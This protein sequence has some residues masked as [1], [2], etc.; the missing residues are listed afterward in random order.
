MV[1]SPASWLK[2][3]PIPTPAAP[4]PWVGR[5]APRVPLVSTHQKVG[6]DHLCVFHQSGLSIHQPSLSVLVLSV[7]SA[8]Q[9]WLALDLGGPECSPLRW[10]LLGEGSTPSST[11]PRGELAS[12]EQS[13]R[14]LVSV[15]G[16]GLSVYAHYLIWFS[17]VP[18]DKDT[19]SQFC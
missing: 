2:A 3:P 15:P 16:T 7:A 13:A 19:L 10:F 18:A 5:K 12:R 6:R 1:L 14:I 4:S 17:T 11:V 8:Q 9:Q